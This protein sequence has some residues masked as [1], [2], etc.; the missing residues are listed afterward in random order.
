MRLEQYSYY[1]ICIIIVGLFVLAGSV[2]AASDLLEPTPEA[3]PIGRVATEAEVAK[4]EA[5]WLLSSHSDT[6]DQG[7]GAN[8][9]C[10]R[11]KSPL[12]WNPDSE[13]YLESLDC[14]SCKRV[15]GEER[16][17][18]EGGEPISE[19]NWKDINC[20]ICHI[21]VGDSV[22]V[23]IAYW[24]QAISG[25]EPV[26]NVM[27][28]CAKCHEGIHGFEVVEE[29]H[30]SP[31]HKGWECTTCHG[32]HGAPSSCEDCHDPQESRG[33]FEHNRH[34][35]VNCTACHDAGDL[36]IMQDED[37]GS[38]HFGQFIPVRFAH[39]LT[40]WPSHNISSEISCER[41][42][43]PNMVGDPAVDPSTP[44]QA[45]HPDGAMWIWC[46]NF[47]RDQDPFSS[48]EDPYE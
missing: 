31:A 26:D 15:P 38:K 34:E 7:M 6:Y 11:C 46:T 42:H 41:C 40:S 9:T 48:S 22:S 36:I 45:C 4:A 1:L 24:N 30:S 12:N 8:T 13:S 16:P 27:E 14:F 29:Q 17:N 44:C 28:L 37:P 10:A 33:V 21:P 32:P 5:E 25:Y 35:M 23:E 47:G 43:H 19:E 39:T 18:L 2:S 20:D 3:P